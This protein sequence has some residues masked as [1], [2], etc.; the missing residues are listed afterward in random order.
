MVYIASQN[1]C[2]LANSCSYL[3]NINGSL[4]ILIFG[5]NG[6][7]SLQS[8]T[9]LGNKGIFM[10]GLVGITGIGQ[11]SGILLLS[12]C[13]NSSIIYITLCNIQGNSGG[14]SVVYVAK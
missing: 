2:F 6:F 5:Y 14:K 10:N 11:G 9:V 3:H 12:S 13:R 4:Q 8:L 1:L 7:A